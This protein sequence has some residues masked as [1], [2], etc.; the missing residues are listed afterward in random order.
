MYTHLRVIMESTNFLTGPENPASPKPFPLNNS[1]L[2]PTNPSN[3]RI[4]ESNLGDLDSFRDKPED[5]GYNDIH[6]DISGQWRVTLYPEIYGIPESLMT[7]LSQTISLVNEKPSLEFAGLSN[8]VIS[9]ALKQHIKTLEQQ[10][11]SWTPESAKIPAGP[12]RPEALV[13]GDSPPYDKPDA[14]SLILAIHQA[15]IIY[16]YRRVYNMSAMIVQDQVQKALDY[17]QPCLEVAKYDQDFAISIGWALFIAACEAATPELQR[18]GLECLE[19]ID[20]HGIFIDASK[21]SSIAQSV[22]DQRNLSG[23]MTYSWPDMMTQVSG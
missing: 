22:W 23:D 1:I 5:I 3:F 14:R 8:P 21:P 10:I 20:D 12:E 16:F 7:L 15:V 13:S 18:Q 2:S 19:A 4:S 6:L 11:W 9:V 17:I